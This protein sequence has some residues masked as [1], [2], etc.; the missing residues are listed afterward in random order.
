MIASDAAKCLAVN[1]WRDEDQELDKVFN[2]NTA[3]HKYCFR[4]DPGRAT[5]FWNASICGHA[6]TTLSRECS[7]RN[8]LRC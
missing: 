1:T 3:F 7:E 4:Q 8:H 6:T 5:K 2:F